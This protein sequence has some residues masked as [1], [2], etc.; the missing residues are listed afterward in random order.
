MRIN[1]T[2]QDGASETLAAI[3]EKVTSLQPLNAALGKRA[4][5]EL[6]AH[7]EQ[8]NGQGNARG[9]PAQH[10][11]ARIRTATAFGGAD[12]TA[13]RVVISDPA[14]NQKIFG[15]TITPREGK[16]LAL[17][18]IAE[19]YGRSPRTM[20]NLMALIRYRGGAR[21]AV[22]LVETQSSAISFGRARKDGSRAVKRGGASWGGRVWY[23]LVKSVTQRRDEG[24]LPP[25][26]QMRAALLDE[27]RQYLA[28][29]G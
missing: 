23:W 13:A 26:E 7:F 21:R 20:D 14:I 27:A 11:W 9:W 8:R 4:E 18:A 5:V 1:L 24:A 29:L 28:R 22:A 19:A 25:D 3:A 12:E 2:E 16:Y 10:F 6:R 17:P 15:G